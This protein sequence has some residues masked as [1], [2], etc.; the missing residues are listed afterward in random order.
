MEYDEKTIF[1]AF[2]LY[3]ELAAK[4]TLVK[5]DYADLY[6]DD[7]V[8]SLAERYA[9]RV[10]CTIIDDADFI[11]LIPI[12]VDSPFHM[13]NE[14][15]KKEYMPTKY[16]NMDVYL[17][18]L[19]IIV[20]MGCFYDSYNTYEP[21]EFVTLQGWLEQMNQRMEALGSRKEEELKQLE[22]EY[23]V[24]WLALLRKW[25]DMDSVKETVK[26]QDARTQSRTGVLTVSKNFL[27]AQG[28]L[29][30]QGNDEF[31]LTEKAK[32]IFTNY[33]LEEKFNHGIMDFMYSLDHPQKEEESQALNQ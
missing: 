5:A 11:Y 18:Y 25:N 19:T 23:N 4:G 15:I 24:N 28:L 7:I 21:H 3:S 8:R 33:Y 31:A 29:H 16:L 2:T 17:V 32:T 14:Q 20:L 10:Q 22:T 26:K 30:D 13:T 6:G 12:A 1:N 27:I 9:E